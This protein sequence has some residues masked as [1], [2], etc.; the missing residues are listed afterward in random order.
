M[1]QRKVSQIKMNFGFSAFFT[2]GWF[3]TI[4]DLLLVLA[5]Y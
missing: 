5:K 1:D 4:T 2:G 3:A